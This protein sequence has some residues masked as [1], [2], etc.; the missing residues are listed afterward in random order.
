MSVAKWITDQP[1]KGDVILESWV[2]FAAQ[3]SFNEFARYWSS[4]MNSVCDINIIHLLKLDVS[5]RKA[6][7]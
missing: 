4:Q 3:I 1:V 2:Q 5:G 6:H 7:I